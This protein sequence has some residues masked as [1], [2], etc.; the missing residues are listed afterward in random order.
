M[1]IQYSTRFAKQFKKLPSP[2]QEL[3]EDKIVIFQSDPFDRR[4]KTHKLTGEL[5]DFWAF[6]I[7]YSYRVM[8]YFLDDY[9]IRLS[10]IGDH[11]IYE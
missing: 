1:H 5:N 9:T 10:A 4:L 7:N 11:D 8:F 6:R 2:I 3:A